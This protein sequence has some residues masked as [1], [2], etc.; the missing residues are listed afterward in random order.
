MATR[1]ILPTRAPNLCQMTCPSDSAARAPNRLTVR[2]PPTTPH[3]CPT[4]G[5]LL[6]PPP[7]YTYLNRRSHVP[8]QPGALY[9]HLHRPHLQNHLP[10]TAKRV[11]ETF[12]ERW[13]SAGWGILSRSPAGGL[14]SRSFIQSQT[15]P[16]QASARARQG[17]RSAQGLQPLSDGALRD[18]GGGA[19]SAAYGPQR[20]GRG[21]SRGSQESRADLRSR[22]APE[23]AAGG[24]T[25]GRHP[26]NG[27]AATPTAHAYAG[28]FKFPAPPGGAFQDLRATPPRRAVRSHALRPRPSRHHR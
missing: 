16:V 25:S 3:I 11:Q 19:P 8:S 12:S 27:E 1:P 10:G 21:R 9:R 23:S 18:M 6:A 20:P 17:H 15:F 14:Q 26:S 2:S 24:V 4:S 13:G 7:R 22:A 28:W 5:T